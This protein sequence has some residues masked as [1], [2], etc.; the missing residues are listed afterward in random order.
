FLQCVLKEE[1]DVAA[2]L[3]PVSQFCRKLF[4]LS[5]SSSVIQ[6]N[7]IADTLRTFRYYDYG[8]FPFDCPYCVRNDSYRVVQV[9]SHQRARRH[10]DNV[11]LSLYSLT[12]Q[13]SVL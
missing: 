8:S 9:G 2:E 11:E 3:E 5:K 12:M 1:I 4:G 7:R 13:L 6:E 10:N